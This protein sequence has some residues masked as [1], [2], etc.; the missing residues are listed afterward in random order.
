MKVGAN[1][2]SLHSLETQAWCESIEYVA[3]QAVLG[4]STGQ[5][6]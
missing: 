4:C 1:K 6:G 3:K 5:S 2:Q